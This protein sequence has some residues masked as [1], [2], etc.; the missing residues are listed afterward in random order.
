MKT[1]RAIRLR[2]ARF[3]VR[4][5]TPCKSLHFV[6]E[7]RATLKKKYDGYCFSRKG[8]RVYN[9]FSLLRVLANS[10]YD[11]YW[12]EN[13]TPSYLVKFLRRTRVPIQNLEENIEIDADILEDF[14]YNDPNY[15]IHYLFYSGYLTIKEYLCEENRFILGFPNDEVRSGFLRGLL[16]Y[17]RPDVSSMGLP[18]DCTLC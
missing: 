15:I 10:A 3:F 13:A 12:F 14:R 7:T 2:V 11:Y 6:E 5:L 1:K 17:T 4:A 9:P 8:G 16:Y 18:V